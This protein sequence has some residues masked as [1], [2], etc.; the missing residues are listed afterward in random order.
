MAE[1]AGALMFAPPKSQCHGRHHGLKDKPS[2]ELK[3]PHLRSSRKIKSQ[4][5]SQSDRQTAINDRQIDDAGGGEQ[6]RKPLPR[7]QPFMEEKM[8]R[9]TFISGFIK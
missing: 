2:T 4:C 9:Q 6:K 3:G 5:Q 8:P 1:S 7:P